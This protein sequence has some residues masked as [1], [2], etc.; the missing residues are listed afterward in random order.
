MSI[1][2]QFVQFLKSHDTTLSN[3]WD[4]RGCSPIRNSS[5]MIITIFEKILI[6]LLK[7]IFDKIRKIMRKFDVKFNSLINTKQ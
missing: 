4:L 6:E 1:L 7:K 5:V 3:K 2:H